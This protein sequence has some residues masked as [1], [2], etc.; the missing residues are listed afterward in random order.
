LRAEVA[1]VVLSAPIFVAIVLL[2]VIFIYVFRIILY[3]PA[4]LFARNPLPLGHGLSKW[5]TV[6]VAN[7]MIGTILTQ[8]EIEGVTLRAVARAAFCARG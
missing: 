5:P 7:G 4:R 3:I 6:E 8:P 1:V 2:A